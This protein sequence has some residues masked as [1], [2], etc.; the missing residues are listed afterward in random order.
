MW[1]E[2]LYLKP[3]EWKKGDFLIVE[4]KKSKI[5]FVETVDRK[6]NQIWTFNIHDNLQ[7]FNKCSDRIWKIIRIV[8]G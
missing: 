6:D 3:S 7:I 2:I 4:E 8:E 1:L 5:Y